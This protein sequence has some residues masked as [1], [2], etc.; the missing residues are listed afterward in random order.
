MAYDMNAEGINGVQQTTY[1]VNN[2]GG[3]GWIL[4]PPMADGFA[5]L[6]VN[7][8]QGFAD[9]ALAAVQGVGNG[10]GPGVIGSVANG[11]GFPDTGAGVAGFNLFL[12][13]DGAGPLLKAA[14]QKAGVYGEC[15]FGPG[16]KGQGGNAQSSFPDLPI[17]AGDGVLGIG[18]LSAP[19]STTTPAQGQT[20]NLLAKPAGVGVIGLGGGA[21]APAATAGTGV[22]GMGAPAQ[23]NF[24]AGRG[25]IFGSAG[26]VAQLQLVPATS[27]TEP[28]PLTGLFGDLYLSNHGGAPALFLCVQPSVVKPP[29]PALW[30]Q[31]GFTGG[32]QP[33]GKPPKPVTY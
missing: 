32:L 19:A 28:L 2:T 5:L 14:T 29:S 11:P 9:P 8:Y 7:A 23:N 33:G 12:V 25:A 27:T 4:P 17:T 13:T 18:G 15:D 3:G 16:V 20:I 26:N 21:S 30:V 24:E 6:Y 1:L 10:S 22:V 31:L